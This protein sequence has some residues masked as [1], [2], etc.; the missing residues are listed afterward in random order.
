MS[1]PEVLRS[2][3]QCFAPYYLHFH[4]FEVQTSH[5]C[6]AMGLVHPLLGKPAPSLVGPP[7]TTAHAT[8]SHVPHH[9]RTLQVHNEVLGYFPQ[10]GFPTSPP[11]PDF[12]QNT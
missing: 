4:H 8:S 12:Y 1:T 2:T 11:F 6:T 5:L 9:L 7:P 10:H 3:P